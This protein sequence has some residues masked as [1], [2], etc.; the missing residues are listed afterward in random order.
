MSG[1]WSLANDTVYV[2][3]SGRR[4]PLARTGCFPGGGGT[5]YWCGARWLQGGL[6]LE[7]PS[8]FS[9]SL[10]TVDMCPLCSP[11]D[12]WPL[13]IPLSPTIRVEALGFPFTLTEMGGRMGVYNLRRSCVWGVVVEDSIGGKFLIPRSLG[14]MWVE[15]KKMFLLCGNRIHQSSGFIS[16]IWHFPFYHCCLWKWVFYR[17]LIS[18]L[19]H[20][21]LINIRDITHCGWV[22]DNVNQLINMRLEPKIFT[23]EWTSVT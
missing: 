12:L 13:D 17:M 20:S 11:K 6:W 4:S 23:V 19:C 22:T 15:N 1:S 21:M 16:G 10:S 8:L 2:N 5:W 14:Q 7:L 3:S 9:E 18:I